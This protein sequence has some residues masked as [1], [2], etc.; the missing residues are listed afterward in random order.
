[1]QS[2]TPALF[3]QLIDRYGAFQPRETSYSKCTSCI[4]WL[5][6]AWRQKRCA[7]V[8]CISLQRL[9]K[10][11]KHNLC[12]AVF[13]ERSVQKQIP[14]IRTYVFAFFLFRQKKESSRPSG[15]HRKVSL[16]FLYKSQHFA[17]CIVANT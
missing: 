13:L 14:R 16:Q 5:W 17:S 10:G 1:M 8:M 6:C 11:I 9:E 3:S 2:C 4:A 12:A 15:Q 7:D